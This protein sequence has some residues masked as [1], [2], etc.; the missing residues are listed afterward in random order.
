MLPV[1]MPII[2]IASAA[3]SANNPLSV[4]NVPTNPYLEEQRGG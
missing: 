4:K 3:S 2:L 1:T